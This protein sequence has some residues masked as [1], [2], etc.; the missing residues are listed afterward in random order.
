MTY[1]VQETSSERLTG[2]I[3]YENPSHL[4]MSQVDENSKFDSPLRDFQN[5][6]P[7][8]TRSYHTEQG[9]RLSLTI[10]V[11]G[12]TWGNEQQGSSGSEDRFPRVIAAHDERMLA[13]NRT[14]DLPQFTLS[15]LRNDNDP[16]T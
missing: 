14:F 4:H 16:T 5:C 10:K 6:T 7:A 9:R 11:A 12:S 1:T 15:N 8:A 13:K 2:W 3:P